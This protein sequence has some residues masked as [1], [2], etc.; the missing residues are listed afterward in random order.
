MCDEM[1]DLPTLLRRGHFRS[2]NL[3]GLVLTLRDLK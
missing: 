1:T 3:A 2:T